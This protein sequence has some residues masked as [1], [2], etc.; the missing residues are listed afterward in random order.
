[1]RVI[2]ERESAMFASNGFAVVVVV[3]P[4]GLW[5]HVEV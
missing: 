1:M 5:S 3:A 4:S 2:I